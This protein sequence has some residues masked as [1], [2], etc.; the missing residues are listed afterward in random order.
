VADR[1]PLE[2][3]TMVHDWLFQVATISL[4]LSGESAFIIAGD[5]VNGHPQKM[6]VMNVVWPVTLYG[7]VRLALS[8]TGRWADRRRLGIRKSRFGSQSW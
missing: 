3:A 6:A 1:E 7:Q 8:R 2:Y 5:I 4:V